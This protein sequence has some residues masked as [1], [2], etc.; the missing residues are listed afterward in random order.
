MVFQAALVNQ[1]LNVDSH[2]QQC[3]KIHSFKEKELGKGN[4]LLD[5]DCV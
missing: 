3:G 4:H 2:P 1:I 5:L